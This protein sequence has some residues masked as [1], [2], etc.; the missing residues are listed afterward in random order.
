MTRSSARQASDFEFIA[1]MALTT[2]LVAMA[3][4]TMLPALG[5][6]A[7]ELGATRANATNDRQ[8]IL[9]S[10]GWPRR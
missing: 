1:L 2:S 5:I 6:M 10:Q 8:L 7:T 9:T 3:I 4:D